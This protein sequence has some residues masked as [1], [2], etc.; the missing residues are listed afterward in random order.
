VDCSIHLQDYSTGTRPNNTSV[1]YAQKCLPGNSAFS[2]IKPYVSEKSPNIP[3]RNANSSNLQHHVQMHH[4]ACLY[5]CHKCTRTFTSSAGLKQ[6]IH[7]HSS[8]KPF[9][10]KVCSKVTPHSDLGTTNDFSF[11]NIV[12]ERGK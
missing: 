2:D 6:H 12:T 10:C 11:M 4:D 7:V 3:V 1:T 8:L 9:L 5:V